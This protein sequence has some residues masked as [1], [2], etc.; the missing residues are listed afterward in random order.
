MTQDIIAKLTDLIVAFLPKFALAMLTLLV[1]FWAIGWATRWINLYFR[2]REFDPTVERFV[3]SIINVALKVMLLLSAAGLFG[4][5]TTSFIAI[6]SALAFAVGTAL[7]GSLGHFASGILVLIFR[8]Y[9]VGD[10]VVLSGQTGY[11]E[12]IQMFNTVLITEDNRK[13]VIP[14][15]VVTSSVI[16]NISGQGTIRVD[17]TFST[18]HGVDIDQ[19]RA[20]VLDVAKTCP[21]LLKNKTVEVWVGHVSGGGAKFNVRPWCKS[22]DYWPTYY[23]FQEHVKKAFARAG[24]PDPGQE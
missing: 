3:S 19:V 8:P 13:V 5:Q 6:F 22:E 2:K 16:T 7:S 24:V 4:V 10:L 21:T 18:G 11:V 20:L 12:E 14:N 17:M 1:G 9:Q 23:Y 15:G